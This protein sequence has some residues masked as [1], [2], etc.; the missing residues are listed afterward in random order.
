MNTGPIDDENRPSEI[1]SSKGSRGLHHVP[2]GSKILMPT[3]IE[4]SAWEYFSGKAE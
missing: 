2:A 1:D 4:K 3:A